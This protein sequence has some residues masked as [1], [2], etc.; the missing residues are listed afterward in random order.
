MEQS[1]FEYIVFVSTSI[2]YKHTGRCKPNL[3]QW[4][5]RDCT[6]DGLGGL[7][8]LLLQVNKAFCFCTLMEIL[9]DRIHKV[10]N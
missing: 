3:F 8:R 4:Q 2:G 9:G 1:Q 6:Q 10:R 5:D 7:L